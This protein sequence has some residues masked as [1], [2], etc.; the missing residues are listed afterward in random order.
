MLGLYWE[1]GK[2][3]GNYRSYRDYIGV[4]IG[5]I[6]GEWKRKWKLQKLYGLYRG[7]FWAS[8]GRMEKKIET[9]LLWSQDFLRCT[10]GGGLAD[11]R[12]GLGV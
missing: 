5:L 11:L 6:L 1:N 4:Y 8:I 9:T 7:I 12:S 10:G 2:E 3:N